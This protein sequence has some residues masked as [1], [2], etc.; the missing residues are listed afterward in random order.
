M[1]LS[2]TTMKKERRNP[3]ARTS[4]SH[5]FK[6]L[7]KSEFKIGESCG[8]V[9]RTPGRRSSR[10]TNMRFRRSMSVCE[11]FL[12]PYRRIEVRKKNKETRIAEIVFQ[13]LM[14]AIIDQANTNPYTEGIEG[15]VF[16]ASIPGKPIE[17]SGW[18]KDLK[19]VCKDVGIEN[20]SWVTF[21][22]WRHFFTTYMKGKVDNKILQMATGHKTPA[23][24]EHSV[25]YRYNKVIHTK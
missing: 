18:L 23:M 2:F 21:H 6:N 14:G 9:Y 10:L 12:E 4:R 20:P 3:Y 22:A 8:N 7:E 17:S 24:L 1:H 15:Y 13:E 16:W 11:A 25:E 5:L 19:E